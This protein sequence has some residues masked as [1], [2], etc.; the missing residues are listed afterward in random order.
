MFVVIYFDIVDAEVE[1]KIFGSYF[2]KI[3]DGTMASY[4]VEY[5]CFVD[6]AVD[7]C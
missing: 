4:T 6:Q 7:C 2:E 3:A 5:Y 1:V